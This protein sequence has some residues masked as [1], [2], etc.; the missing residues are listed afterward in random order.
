MPTATIYPSGRARTSTVSLPSAHVTAL[1]FEE[2]LKVFEERAE[3]LG[4]AGRT[5]GIVGDVHE[6]MI[7]RGVFDRIVIANVLRLESEERA[8][9]L[10]RKAADALMAGGDMVV[11]DAWPG[12]S[13]ESRLD[14]AVYALNLALRTGSGN[15]HPLEAIR[16]WTEE[17]GLKFANSTHVGGNRGVM[18]AVKPE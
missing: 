2:V 8:R 7:P 5:H 4:I 12:E 11:V 3:D 17:S 15:P 6:I 10:I 14:F 16:R 13:D 18:F 1:D 9:S